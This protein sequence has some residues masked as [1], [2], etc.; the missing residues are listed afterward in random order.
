MVVTVRVVP[1]AELFGE[2][3][4]LAPDGKPD[5]EKLTALENP[6][7]GLTLIASVVP[8]PGES[9]TLLDAADSVK[10]A[11][12]VMTSDSV[13]VTEVDPQVPVSVSG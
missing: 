10:F 1:L 3:L 4:P 11:P 8:A 12:A 7:L 2:K 9:V 13:A 5:A 6:L